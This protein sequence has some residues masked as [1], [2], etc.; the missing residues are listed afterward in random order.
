MT[1]DEAIATLT[2]FREESPLKGNTVLCVCLADSELPSSTVSELEL[3]LDGDDSALV[4]IVST[5]HELPKL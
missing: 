4:V 5:D 3:D 1:I 2:R